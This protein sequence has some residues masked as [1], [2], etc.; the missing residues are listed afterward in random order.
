VQVSV[1]DLGD[2]PQEVLKRLQGPH[3]VVRLNGTQNKHQ[4]RALIG[5]WPARQ[6]LWGMH[7][8]LHAIQDHRSCCANVQKPF[9]AQDI[10]APGVQ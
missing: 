5:I 9:G 4:M 10:L 1:V 2:S 3:D 8:V 7:D 6:V